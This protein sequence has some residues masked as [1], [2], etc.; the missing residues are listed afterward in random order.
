MEFMTLLGL[1]RSL[2]AEREMGFIKCYRLRIDFVIAGLFP[3]WQKE[4][5]HIENIERTLRF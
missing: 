1:V 5:N 3:D 4:E 2:C